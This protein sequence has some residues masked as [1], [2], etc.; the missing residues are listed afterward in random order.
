MLQL[1]ISCPRKKFLVPG[2]NEK[3]AEE[4]MGISENGPLSIHV[5]K[6][7]FAAINKYWRNYCNG[8]WN[9]I[10]NKRDN[11]FKQSKNPSLHSWIYNK[12]NIDL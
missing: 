6:L 5:D 2:R 11:M 10:I 3:R 8:E 1:E 12:A 9:F 4:E 7:L